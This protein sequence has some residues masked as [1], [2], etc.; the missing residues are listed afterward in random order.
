MSLEPRSYGTIEIAQKIYDPDLLVI[1]QSGNIAMFYFSAADQV[2]F[3]G[4]EYALSDVC[5]F[6]NY[7]V[8]SGKTKS[9]QLKKFTTFDRLKNKVKIRSS[10]ITFIV[11]TKTKQADVR[12]LFIGE[13]DIVS[14][15][16]S[17]KF[18]EIILDRTL[19]STETFFSPKEFTGA[20]FDTSDF[21]A[22]HLICSDN[23]DV[24][25]LDNCL[26]HG[27]DAWRSEELQLYNEL[28]KDK[29]ETQQEFEARKQIA[30]NAIKPIGVWNINPISGYD[31]E[32]RSLVFD[33]F[34]YSKKG[35]APRIK[36]SVTQTSVNKLEEFAQIKSS[37]LLSDFSI[38]V[39]EDKYNEDRDYLL[40]IS[41][42]IARARDGRLASAVSV[43][44]NL[45]IS[46]SE[47]KDVPE[48]MKKVFRN[49]SQKFYDSDLR[50][51]VILDKKSLEILYDSTNHVAGQG[52]SSSNV[53]LDARPLSCGKKINANLKKQTSN[54]YVLSLN[55]EKYY[56]NQLFEKAVKKPTCGF[57]IKI[58][59]RE[60]PPIFLPLGAMHMIGSHHSQLKL[61]TRQP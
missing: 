56:F 26:Y 4:K 13:K 21:G 35:I 45:S 19:V 6:G 39:S 54:S 53:Q 40:P 51:L 1:A 28:A 27:D 59:E 58:S 42:E 47:E 17:S 41:V 60:G 3:D 12:C 34:D 8:E 15:E 18:A 22:D 36:L 55:S 31:A 32:S 7:K 44:V 20:I 2:V 5:A 37:E 23:D 57:E 24:R 61:Y 25:F 50:R 33:P 38:K 9:A 46:E 52:E 29:F 16:V 11:G 49:H 43:S 48:H 14:S 30:F 10:A